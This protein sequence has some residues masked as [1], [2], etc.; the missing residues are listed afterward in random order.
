MPKRLNDLFSDDGTADTIS[1]SD[2]NIMDML[3]THDF[4]D[5]NLIDT[6]EYNAIQD[7]DDLEE[8]I[9]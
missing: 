1:T 9:C 7:K 4:D 5:N 3:N 6:H 8:L 2:D